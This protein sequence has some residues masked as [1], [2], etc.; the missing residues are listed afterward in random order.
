M[1]KQEVKTMQV[2][3]PL[4]STSSA[5]FVSNRPVRSHE[6]VLCRGTAELLQSL[7]ARLLLNRGS[8]RCRVYVVGQGTAV[9]GNGMGWQSS[10]YGAA[11]RVPEAGSGSVFPNIMLRTKLTSNWAE[12]GAYDTA[13]YRDI[14][15]YYSRS[16]RGKRELHW[17][18]DTIS[19]MYK[20][21]CWKLELHNVPE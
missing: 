9:H 8:E 15:F 20:D 17:C 6:G 18:H 4:S 10:R 1:V 16:C 12:G 21:A 2:K 13:K 3:P 11:R 5:T 19:N 14:T 7:H